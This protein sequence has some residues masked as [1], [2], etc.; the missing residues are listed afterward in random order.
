MLKQYKSVLLLTAGLCLCAPTTSMADKSRTGA[1]ESLSVKV[2]WTSVGSD[3]V[4]NA[5]GCSQCPI[6]LIVDQTTRFY[7]KRKKI[8]GDT[9]DL[10]SGQ[11]GTVI[12]DIADNHALKVIW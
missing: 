1:A 5:D 2:S 3:G 7:V 4:A 10:Y 6:Q 8:S 11:P 9:T 12:Y